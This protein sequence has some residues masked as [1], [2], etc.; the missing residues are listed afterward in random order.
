MSCNQLRENHSRVWT[1]SVPTICSKPILLVEQPTVE[2]VAAVRSIGVSRLTLR[3]AVAGPTIRCRTVVS[4]VGMFVR[5]GQLLPFAVAF[6]SYNN[7]GVSRSTVTL[8]T[9]V[10]MLV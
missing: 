9:A 6:H 1:I 3:G 5:W 8:N 2:T 4:S 7:G 10:L